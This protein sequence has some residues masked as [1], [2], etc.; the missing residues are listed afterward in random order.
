ML[1]LKWLK[2]K[3]NVL[4]YKQL[5]LEEYAPYV[6]VTVGKTSLITR[7]MYDSFDNT[8]QVSETTTSVME[9]NRFSSL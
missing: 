9:S 1:S 3:H 4:K 5:L 6:S 2:Y 7:F 8:Y